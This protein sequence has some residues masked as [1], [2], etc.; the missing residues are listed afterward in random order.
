M[1][2]IYIYC[3]GNVI[4][5]GIYSLHNLC[6][7]L[8]EIGYN[9]CM[10]YHSVDEAI[11]NHE[12]IRSFAVPSVDF[13]NDSPDHVLI[14]SETETLF[15]SRFHSIKKIVYWLALNSYFKKPVFRWPFSIKMLRKAIQCRNYYGYSAGM[16][17][18]IKRSASWWAKANDTIWQGDIIHMSNSHYVARCCQ[19]KG[20]EKVYIL[21]N[22]VREEHY[23]GSALRV[24]KKPKIVFGPK[25]PMNLIWL[26]Q[27]FLPFEIVRLK[28]M[29]PQTVM[30][31]MKEAMV[32]AEYGNYPGRD[33]MPREAA[34]LGCVLCSNI[35][36]SAGY[37]EDM[38]IP[39]KYKI[40]DTV[41][42]YPKIVK[43]LKHCIRNYTSAKDDF[44]DYVRSLQE[45]RV[46]FRANV[47]SVFSEIL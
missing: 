41:C 27:I 6:A 20:I 47:A 36:G 46:N 11:I 10:Y 34:L 24:Q 13:I 38:P 30:E 32:F 4:T 16:L 23:N 37:Y 7:R 42:N 39:V 1:K 22:P 29:L 26:C 12:N 43:L 2:Y 17:E 25:T 35:R 31:H 8:I 45:E 18:N 15:L 9:A 14:V 5:G 3:P 44:V 33:R 40:A 19:S 28:Y 21:H